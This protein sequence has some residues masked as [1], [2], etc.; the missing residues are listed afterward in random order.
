MGSMID[1]VHR[2]DLPTVLLIDDDMVSREVVATLITMGGY[3][4]HTAADG[5]SALNLMANK[6]CEPG[7]ILM[8]AQMPGLS[9]TALIGQLRAAS[10]AAVVVISASAPPKEVA[11][12]A[13]GA[14]LKPFTPDDLTALL[15]KRATAA[16]GAPAA[17]GLRPGELVVNPE[18]LAQLR[19][20]MPETA[21]KQIYEA[22]VA[23]IERRLAAIRTAGEQNDAAEVR[24]L[25]HAIKGGCAMAGAAQAA[26]LGGLI[27]QG[28]L[29]V[30][31]SQGYVNHLDNSAPVLEDL[32][33]AAENLKRMLKVEFPS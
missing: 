9:G 16:G 14:L 17:H 22:I 15:E 5:E 20:M 1:L 13:D 2:N 25:G 18:T 29:E 27:E 11:L 31:G 6:E 10:K 28:A 26:R 12:A 8:D 24:R 21:V 7:V 33:V 3:P 19:E 4:V 23:D 30:T 32:R